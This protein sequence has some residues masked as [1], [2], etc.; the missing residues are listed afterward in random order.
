MLGTGMGTLKP[1]ARYALLWA[2]GQYY[3]LMRPGVRVIHRSIKKTYLSV[4]R[5]YWCH[6][7]DILLTKAEELEDN[8]LLKE[9]AEDFSLSGDLVNV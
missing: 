4:G 7:V 1:L 9:L 5:F 8:Y 6:I 3:F 2:P